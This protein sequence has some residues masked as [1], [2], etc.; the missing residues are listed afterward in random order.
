MAPQHTAPEEANSHQLSHMTHRLLAVRQRFKNS[1]ALLHR[2][3]VGRRGTL[4]HTQPHPLQ[5]QVWL[6]MVGSVGEQQERNHV[7]CITQFILHNK[8]IIGLVCIFNSC[9]HIIISS[10]P[11]IKYEVFTW[12]AHHNKL[13]RSFT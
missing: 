5:G 12:K 11:A 1:P 8:I 7:Y 6:M 4:Q 10:L 3:G 13:S 9:N 2:I